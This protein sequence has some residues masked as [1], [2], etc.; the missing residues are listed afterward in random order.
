[1]KNFYW[2]NF[3]QSLKFIL[4]HPMAI[5]QHSKTPKKQSEIVLAQLEFF[6]H[7]VYAQRNSYRKRLSRRNKEI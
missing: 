5:S 4:I 2:I 6:D 3:N 1:M 7:D